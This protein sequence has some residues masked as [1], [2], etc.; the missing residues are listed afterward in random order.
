[1]GYDG[2]VDPWVTLLMLSVERFREVVDDTPWDLTDVHRD[3]G[4][5]V[6]VLRCNPTR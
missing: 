4:R 1:L 3:D 2:E 6:V 5:Y